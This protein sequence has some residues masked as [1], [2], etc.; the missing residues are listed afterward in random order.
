[1]ARVHGR[2]FVE[3]SL[4]PWSS[5]L[6]ETTAAVSLVDLREAF[7]E[8]WILRC[9]S[10]RIFRS[11]ARISANG[12]VAGFSFCSC[13]TNAALGP[14]GTKNYC[15]SLGSVIRLSLIMADFLSAPASPPNFRGTKNNQIVF[16]NLIAA[17]GHIH[18][19]AA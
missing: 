5:E 18:R 7:F 15:A 17:E 3:L 14:G 11:A 9:H 6:V 10:N 2:R 19:S 13:K 1:V 4:R 8:S 16:L 12:S